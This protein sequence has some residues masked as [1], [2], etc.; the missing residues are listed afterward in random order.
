[1]ASI[2]GNGRLAR[3]EP[4]KGPL[5]RRAL[6][7]LVL[8]TTAC[9]LSSSDAPAN[10]SLTVGVVQKEIRIG[11]SGAEVAEALGAPNIVTTDEERREVW[12]YERYAREVESAKDG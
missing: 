4:S 12:I 5:L 10:R 1:M 8:A 3:K 6:P 9:K 7:V 11:M 2:D